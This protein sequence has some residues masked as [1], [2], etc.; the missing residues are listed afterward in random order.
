M[1]TIQFCTGTDFSFDKVDALYSDAGWSAYTSDKDTLEKA[2]NNSLFV[3]TAW[4]GEQLIGLLRAVGDGLTI[5]YVQ[6]ILVLQSYRRQSIG[7]QLLMQLLEKYSTVRQIV[8]MTDNTNET[9]SFYERCGLTRTENLQIQT[10]VRL[11][12]N[13]Q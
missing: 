5:V 13:D 2:I 6:D 9:T 11:M 8:L 7:R 10:F 1:T 12:T 3:L 4:S